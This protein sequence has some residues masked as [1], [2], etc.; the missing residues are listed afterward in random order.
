MTYLKLNTL[1][2]F[3]FFLFLD[4]KLSPLSYNLMVA[5]CSFNFIHVFIQQVLII[6]LENIQSYKEDKTQLQYEVTSTLQWEIEAA[7]GADGK[8]T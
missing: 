7:M 2:H 3:Q 5:Q 6:S 4:V 1:P 8:S